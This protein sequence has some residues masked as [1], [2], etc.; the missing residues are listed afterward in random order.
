M[1]LRLALEKKKIIL[2]LILFFFSWKQAP[3]A[4]YS[5]F[6]FVRNNVFIL[7]LV[8]LITWH[9]KNVPHDN[10]RLIASRQL[11][12]STGTV[13]CWYFCATQECTSENNGKYR[14]M[15]NVQFHSYSHTREQALPPTCLTFLFPE[16]ISLTVELT[17]KINQYPL[18]F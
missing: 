18:P 9:P 3:V 11:S 10:L 6:E 12:M 2:I 4:E 14:Y 17:S 15:Q 16:G 1:Q 13:M 7:R 8:Q 5:P